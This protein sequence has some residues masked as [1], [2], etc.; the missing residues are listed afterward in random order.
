MTIMLVSAAVF[1]NMPSETT[2][3]LVNGESPAITVCSLRV[4]CS[5]D[6]RE[7]AGELVKSITKPDQQ[8]NAILTVLDSLEPLKVVIDML[9][10][11]RL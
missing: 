10:E 9:A 4:F 5:G 3:S 11:V 2:V 1:F 7:V 8:A 6:S